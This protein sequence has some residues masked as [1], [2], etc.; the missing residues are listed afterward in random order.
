M[1]AAAVTAAAASGVRAR[2]SLLARSLI[3][4]IIFHEE[5]I[6]LKKKEEQPERRV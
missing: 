5:K 3:Q 6:K 2:A 4:H 1:S